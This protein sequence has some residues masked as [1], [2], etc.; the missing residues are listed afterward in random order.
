MVVEGWSNQ[1][2]PTE[3]I[4][5]VVSKRGVVLPF[6]PLTISFDEI[7]YY[8]DMPAVGNYLNNVFRIT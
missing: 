8:V 7:N 5:S 4:G 2:V 3:T 6:K 1:I